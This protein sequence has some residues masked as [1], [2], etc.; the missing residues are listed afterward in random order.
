MSNLDLFD[1]PDHIGSDQP[2]AQDIKDILQDHDYEVVPA[3]VLRKKGQKSKSAARKATQRQN[4]AEKGLAD[5]TMTL[6]VELHPQFR[7]LS[8][9]VKAGTPLE[10]ALTEVFGEMR[11]SEPGDLGEL[12]NSQTTGEPLLAD[13]LSVLPK[14]RCYIIRLM[15]HKTIKATKWE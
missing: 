11:L 12:P 3:E 1:Q 13:I 10:I 9:L 5:I 8:K 15:L 14:W 6:P 4:D 2:L 7:V